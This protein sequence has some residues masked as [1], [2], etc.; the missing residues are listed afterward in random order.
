M[1]EDD[2]SCADSPMTSTLRTLA[3]DGEEAELAL[4]SDNTSAASGS[5]IP[6]T[7]FTNPVLDDIILMIIY[8]YEVKCGSVFVVDLMLCWSY[9]HFMMEVTVTLH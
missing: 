5:S 9:I 3:E 8:Q 1:E 7:T 6:T 4:A 2:A